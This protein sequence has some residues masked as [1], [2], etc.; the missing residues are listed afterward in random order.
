MHFLIMKNVSFYIL[1]L[2]IGC[3]L[4]PCYTIKVIAQNKCNNLILDQDVRYNDLIM[5]IPE[6]VISTLVEKPNRDGALGRNKNGYFHVRFQLNMTGL[7]DYAFKFQNEL[8]LHKFM[9]NLNYSFSHQD[10]SGGFY[11][12]L[13]KNMIN[14]PNY[15][16]PYDAILAS[17]TAF[18]AYSLGISLNSLNQSDW[19]NNS[20]SLGGIRR[21]IQLLKPNFRHMLN[22]LKEKV[23]LLKEIDSNA[24]NR[25]L[26]DAIA[27][28][29]LGKYL[30]DKS[31]MDIGTI[32]TKKAISQINKDEG[33]FIEGDGWDSS[34]NGVAIKL[35]FELITLLEPSDEEL[36]SELNLAATC[37]TFWQKTRISASGEI[38]AE[39]NTRVYLGG[40]KFLGNEKAVDVMETVKG[41]Y[42]MSTLSSDNSYKLS[43]LKILDYYNNKK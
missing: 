34:Y 15:Q 5:D 1:A 33:Y 13:P 37:A 18:F 23:G 4:L 35:A 10:Q 31:A 11:L 16:P 20:T 41:F 26:F 2:F 29:G 12:K 39:G 42:Y 30:N 8:A 43:A 19:F 14:S 36:K 28:Y 21:D 40:E 25:L 9:D 38:S 17:G 7:T 24:P 3:S 6:N 32:F 27:F 22:Y